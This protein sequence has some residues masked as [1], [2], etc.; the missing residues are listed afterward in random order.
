[1]ACVEQSKLFN[2][3]TLPVPSPEKTEGSPYEN[4]FTKYKFQIQNYLQK[5][6]K[7]IS[8]TKVFAF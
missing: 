8:S 6:K 4:R 5:E 1:M 2:I 3:D 7:T